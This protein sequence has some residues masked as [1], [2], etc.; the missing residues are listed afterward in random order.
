MLW[1]QNVATTETL[2]RDVRIHLRV[3]AAGTWR[4]WTWPDEPIPHVVDDFK[5]SDRA[6]PS[7]QRRHQTRTAATDD[8]STDALI[9]T[10]S[11][12]SVCL[13]FYQR[14]RPIQRCRTVVFQIC[15][16]F[17]G[18]TDNN[19]TSQSL[20]V[21]LTLLLN[22]QGWHDWPNIVRLGTAAIRQT[23]RQARNLW[24][25]SS[26]LLWLQKNSPCCAALRNIFSI[27]ITGCDRR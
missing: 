6:A 8:P 12:V 15:L 14:L 16:C 5:P 21:A 19:Y 7:S 26:D 27:T 25:C 20:G 9:Q 2:S 24:R 17:E 18:D 4:S 10:L 22:L 13:S 11:Q 23:W 1:H 3:T